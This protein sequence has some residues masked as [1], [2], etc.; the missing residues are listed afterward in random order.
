VLQGI[1]AASLPGMNAGQIYSL[2]SQDYY[3]W[4]SVAS[5]GTNNIWQG[6][7]VRVQGICIP[8]NTGT[9]GFAEDQTVVG[10]TSGATAQIRAISGTSSGYIVVSSLSAAFTVGEALTVAGTTLGICSGAAVVAIAEKIVDTYATSPQI[11]LLPVCKTIIEGITFDVPAGANVEAPIGTANRLPGLILANC[12]EPIVRNVTCK[13]GWTR[14]LQS[15][16]NWRLRAT[17]VRISYLPDDANLSEGA[18][19]YGIELG[20]PDTGA[21]VEGL[22]ATGCRH[23]FT[24]NVYWGGYSFM[25]L[26]LRGNPRDFLVAG[27]TG[28]DCYNAA[29]DTHWGSYGG[30]FVD[31]RSD[32]NNHTNRNVSASIGFQNRGF[33]TT[34]SGCY[35]YKC[36]N[37]FVDASTNLPSPLPP[38]G[39]PSYI[40][41]ISYGD[42]QAVDFQLNGFL[43]AVADVTGG[44]RME[45]RNC[46]ARGDGLAVGAPYNQ[47]CF[48]FQTSNYVRLI[49]CGAERFNANCFQF[50]AGGRIEILD[51]WSY[52]RDNPNATGG[53]RLNGVPTEFYISNYRVFSNVTSST[54]AG[55]IRNA[56]GSSIT[57]G[58]SDAITCVNVPTT[59]L[60]DPAS[61]GA[62]AFSWGTSNADTLAVNSV[63]DFAAG[64]VTTTGLLTSNPG[65]GSGKLWNNGGV[66]SVA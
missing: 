37:G 28:R 1:A 50:A 27:G 29:F 40:S 62:L 8:F 32:S 63:I 24:T 48:N 30:R 23:G 36:V 64:G 17:G 65:A 55:L 45:L 14:F 22:I 58:L 26:Q 39:Q 11:Q 52:Y 35:A 6:Q 10:G 51:C 18:Y 49:S 59:P 5:G 12:V 57:I 20:G 13:S 7:I 3:P 43:A 46:K 61:T 41:I 9:G 53:M 15:L 21:L 25:P 56:S 38:S 54:P 2:N 19:G 47:T 60:V 16:G 33:N 31:C 34:Y 4:A 66:V 44:N 42:C